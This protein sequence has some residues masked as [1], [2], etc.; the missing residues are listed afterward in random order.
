MNT[1]EYLEQFLNRLNG[2]WGNRDYA[3]IDAQKVAVDP[4]KQAQ[5]DAKALAEAQDLAYRFVA[6]P[7]HSQS[8]RGRVALKD[9]IARN[10]AVRS[11]TEILEAVRKWIADYNPSI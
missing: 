4:D 3:E 9:L 2:A 1:T 10:K 7:N 5:A 8:Q 6:G 11:G